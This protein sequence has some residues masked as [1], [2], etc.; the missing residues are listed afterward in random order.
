MRAFIF[1]LIVINFTSCNDK[2]E[3]PHCADTINESFAPCSQELTVSSASCIIKE[4]IVK[5]NNGNQREKFIYHHN[6]INYFQIDSHTLQNDGSFTEEPNSIIQLYY[7]QDRV[8]STVVSFTTNSN[9]IKTTYSYSRST[10]T[11]TTFIDTGGANDATF[12]SFQLYTPFAKDSTYYYEDTSGKDLDLSYLNEMKGG[13]RIRM[14][15]LA[16]DGTCSWYGRKWKFDNKAYYD[17]L[18]N[19]LKDQAIRY[20]FNGN[21]GLP[22]FFDQFWVQTNLNNITGSVFDNGKIVEKTSY[23]YTFIRDATQKLWLKKLETGGV[24]IVYTYDCE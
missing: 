22:A 6:G 2:N 18:S 4:A 14:G 16:S 1:V 13:N 3:S 5:F 12:T 24:N 8:I 23:C 9:L 15:T 17:D 20:P 19:V 21:N 7:D 11:I 10:V